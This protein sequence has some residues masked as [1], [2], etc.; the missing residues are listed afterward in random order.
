MTWLCIKASQTF[1][2]TFSGNLLKLT[3][4]CTKASQTFS[5][6]L[7]W[8][9][10]CNLLC[11]LLWNL[12]EA[13]VAPKPPRTFSGTLLNLTWLCTNA[14]KPSPETSLKPCW[15]WRGSAPK[16][17]LLRNL[18]EPS[19]TC[20]CNLHLA[21]HRNPLQP[22]GT[23]RNLRLQFAPGPVPEPSGTFRNL[24]EPS[25]TCTCNLTLPCTGT[26]RNLLEPAPAT[27][28]WPCTGTFRNLRLPPAPAHTWACLGWRPH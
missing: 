21:L 25:G 19:G 14:S 26:L 20:S 8:N 7:L 17:P 4:L 24:P 28:T 10:L 5:G 1:S 12:V 3:W 23:F 13:D 16:P 6:N 15:T 22:S 9:L 11:N 2:G 18:A 27:C